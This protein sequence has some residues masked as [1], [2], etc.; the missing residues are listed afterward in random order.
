VTNGNATFTTTIDFT[1]SDGSVAA[2]HDT[3]RL[4]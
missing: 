4:L 3:T 1:E 2:G